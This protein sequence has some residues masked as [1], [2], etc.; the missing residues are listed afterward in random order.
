VIDVLY[1]LSYNN[2][3][4]TRSIA[5]PLCDSRA[6]CWN[7]VFTTLVTD[8][9]TNGRTDGQPENTMPLSVR[10]EATDD[11]S[12]MP[13]T[14]R[15]HCWRIFPKERDTHSSTPVYSLRVCANALIASTCRHLKSHNRFYS[16][17]ILITPLLLSP[18]LSLC[19]FDADFLRGLHRMS[20][21]PRRR[22]TSWCDVNLLTTGIRL[23]YS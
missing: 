12:T 19:L 7:I 3:W 14:R 15:R 11:E 8:E 10:L 9:R 6:T 23:D 20:C 17:V 1:Y 13:K 22:R 18:S 5:R 4:Q 21:S 16:T 2:Y